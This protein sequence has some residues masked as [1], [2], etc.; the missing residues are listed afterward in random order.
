MLRK[1]SQSIH[2]PRKARTFH[3]WFRI[4]HVFSWAPLLV[5]DTAEVVSSSAT[6]SKYRY[7]IL[8]MESNSGMKVASDDMSTNGPNCQH[9]TGPVPRS[10][11]DCMAN[12]SRQDVRAPT[13]VAAEWSAPNALTQRGTSPSES[14]KAS[15]EKGASGQ[16][17]SRRSFNGISSVMTHPI[18]DSITASPAKKSRSSHGPN[19]SLR[20]DSPPA[21]GA[22]S[23]AVDWR[24]VR[25]SST[26]PLHRVPYQQ[27]Q[28]KQQVK[29]EPK[30]EHGLQ[31]QVLGVNCVVRPE[32]SALH[33]QGAPPR[34][35]T[36]DLRRNCD[37]CVEKKVRCS[38][39]IPCT[40]CLRKGL[41]CM[42][43]L[44]QKPGPKKARPLDIPPIEYYQQVRV[45]L[46]S[47][48]SRSLQRREKLR[49]DAPP[50]EKQKQ[51]QQAP[52]Q[53]QPQP[54]RPPLQQ[55][56]QQPQRPPLQ[57]PQQQ[58]QQQQ[59]HTVVMED[60]GQRGSAPRGYVPGAYGNIYRGASGT[61]VPPSVHLQLQLPSPVNNAGEANTVAGR[62]AQ[63]LHHFE[64]SIPA[65]NNTGEANAAA[66]CA[67][68]EVHFEP[69]IP[70]PVFS[71]SASFTSP[72]F[73]S[74]MSSFS[75]SPNPSNEVS[76][77]SLALTPRYRRFSF[78]ME[79]DSTS[80]AKFTFSSPP[81]LANGGGVKNEGGGGRGSGNGYSLQTHSPR[82]F[83]VKESAEA[84][85]AL[86][87]GDNSRLNA[88]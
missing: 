7:Y 74:F 26:P 85:I 9:S 44:K 77:F 76:G 58:P 45:H 3:R 10:T 41:T 52:Q 75:P 78:G 6:T 4:P 59:E 66:G 88:R 64:S 63:G 79:N 14:L 1:P 18:E 46:A 23:K 73:P 65:T 53:K 80:A 68:H 30:V 11:W 84:L 57:Q 21:I 37:Y 22:Q 67:A 54:L 24:R 81:S 48:R 31:E 83:E 69:S 28:K 47:P 8:E 61:A 62:G 55:P 40:M 60:H 27:R 34:S 72:H 87:R 5:G 50:C 49:Q 13:V 86:R 51:R 39:S 20:G 82:E 17:V 42:F 70:V 38:G 15:R 33:A 25:A 29:Q 43:S 56:Q 35:S 12:T 32:V 71:K 36:G 2:T 16:L 19:A